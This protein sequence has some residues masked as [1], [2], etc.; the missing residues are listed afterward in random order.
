MGETLLSL[1]MNYC[2]G[3][4]IILHEPMHRFFN[5]YVFLGVLKLFNFSRGCV[6]WESYICSIKQ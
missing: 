2:S 6:I 1:V 5:K 4:C 3:P